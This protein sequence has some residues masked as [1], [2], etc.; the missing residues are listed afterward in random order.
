MFTREEGLAKAAD[1]ERAASE[2][3]SAAKRRR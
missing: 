1:A 3:A 2:A